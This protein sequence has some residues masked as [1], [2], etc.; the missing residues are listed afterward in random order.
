MYSLLFIASCLIYLLLPSRSLFYDV[1]HFFAR[2]N[3]SLIGQDSAQSK[4]TL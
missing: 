2:A 3:F 4:I 1:A